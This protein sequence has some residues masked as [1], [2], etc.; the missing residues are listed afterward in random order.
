MAPQRSDSGPDDTSLDWPPVQQVDSNQAYAR[1]ARLYDALFD[2]L[3]ADAAFY[4][5]AA[6]TY[7]PAHDQLLELGIGTGRLT[8]HL[9]RDGRRVV[10]LDAS[11]Q[12]LALAAQKF[13]ECADLELICDDVRRFELGG[14]SFPLVVAPYGMVAHLLTDD[15]RL[16]AFRSVY[17][18]LKP[19]GV[20]IFDD[21]PSWMKESDD[22]AAMHVSLVRADPHGGGMVRLMTNTIDAADAPVSVRYDFIDRLDADGRV[23]QRTVVRIVFRNIALADELQLLERSGFGRVDILGG[24]DGRTLDVEKPVDGVRLILRCHRDA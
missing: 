22:S 17:A 18:H 19:G 2:G 3:N 13:G 11:P 23:R 1:Y 8:A 20:F 5:A 9:L 16:A 10:G 12:M 4:L 24:F 21:C 14:R 6:Q 15:D 7:V